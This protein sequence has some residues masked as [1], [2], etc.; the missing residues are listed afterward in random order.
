MSEISEALREHLDACTEEKERLW[1]Y[2]SKLDKA[3]E[4]NSKTI[5]TARKAFWK[6]CGI[7]GTV[8]TIALLSHYVPAL[9]PN[10]GIEERFDRL[11]DTLEVKK[12]RL[13]VSDVR[14]DQKDN[15]LTNLEQSFGTLNE[16][17]DRLLNE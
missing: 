8:I 5:E 3:V 16:K 17:L 6:A 1:K 14:L 10:R 12:Q 15:R 7:I 4:D 13:D 2:I 11:M 9:N